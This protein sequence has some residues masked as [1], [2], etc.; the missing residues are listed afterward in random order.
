MQMYQ[1]KIKRD[2]SY[3][4]RN[5]Y[6][7]FVSHVLS[8]DLES[9]RCFWRDNLAGNP[10][11]AFPEVKASVSKPQ[12]WT[13]ASTRH[14]FS[15]PRPQITP[16]VAL[17]AAWSHLSS[18]YGGTDDVV[19]G[20]ACTGRDIPNLPHSWD[21][22]GP[23]VATL[24][25][26]VRLPTDR[27]VPMSAFLQT[28]QNA[29]AATTLHEHCGLREIRK[30]SSDAN[31][32][33]GF[34]SLLI[35]QTTSKSTG[36]RDDRDEL[37]ETEMDLGAN[38]HPYP[39]VLEATLL[40]SLHKIN[41]TA[42]YDSDL[43]DEAAVQRLLEQLGHMVHEVVRLVESEG[44]IGQI[45]FLSPTDKAHIRDWNSDPTTVLPVERCVHDIVAERV[46]LHPDSPAVC[47]WDMILTYVELDHFATRL[48]E[49]LAKLGLKR[50]DFVPICHEK[51][52]WSVVAQLAVLKVGA[53]CV[54]LD[55][56]YPKGN[57]W[58]LKAL[59]YVVLESRI[60][61]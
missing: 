53:A 34:H 4:S 3:S 17:Y 24:P 61:R 45:D 55:P 8:G 20:I 49:Q 31:T 44:T 47:A 13:D 25:L 22:V 38:V 27:N 32:A 40:D 12:P 56:S 1:G 60:S 11:N 7:R 54:S 10:F 48:A 58:P 37:L 9:Q 50:A 18:T 26:R 59:A 29:V 51:S 15:F 23:M 6:A 33:C 39:L 52:A 21:I 28:V 46:L 5:P 2:D 41:V 35:V 43:M 30:A 42:H 57:F 16:S 36:L 14:L 19:F